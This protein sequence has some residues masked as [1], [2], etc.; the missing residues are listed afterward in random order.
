VSPLIYPAHV[1]YFSPKYRAAVNPA[2]PEWQ[3]KRERAFRFWGR[4]C[5]WCESR[6]PLEVHHAFGYK[7]LGHENRFELV[8]LCLRAITGLP[9]GAGRVDGGK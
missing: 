4:R 7:R 1:P 2:N 8:P 5:W 6:G 9:R 3:A